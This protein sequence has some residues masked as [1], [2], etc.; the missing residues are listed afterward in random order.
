MK[1][2][3]S[4]LS[5]ALVATLTVAVFGNGPS[6]QQPGPWTPKQTQEKYVAYIIDGQ[7][8]A[9]VEMLADFDQLSPEQKVQLEE[10]VRILSQQANGGVIAYEAY[11]EIYSKDSTTCRV[12]GRY[13][14]A[15]DKTNDVT[16]KLKKTERGWACSL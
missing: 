8:D 14:Y 9:A 5:L 7:W 2:V 11:E 6:N 1:T 12:K 15:N 13:T 16:D 4:I 10:T 3:A